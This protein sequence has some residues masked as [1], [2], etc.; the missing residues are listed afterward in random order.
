M[1]KIIE[2]RIKS[3]WEEFNEMAEQ[4]GMKIPSDDTPEGILVR[5]AFIFGFLEGRGKVCC[6]ISS[7]LCLKK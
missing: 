7:F 6:S 1:N 4:Q 3:L 5:N 2:E